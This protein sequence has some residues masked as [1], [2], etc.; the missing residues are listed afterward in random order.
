MC[1]SRCRFV[2]RTWKRSPTRGIAAHW[3]YKL[4]DKSL[5][6]PHARAREWLDN[7]VELQADANSEEFLESVKIDLF[8]DK[9]YVFTPRG[10]IRR[11]PRGAT[12]VDFAYAVHTEIGNRCVSAMVD[13]RRVPLRTPLRNG[14]TVEIVTQRGAKPNPLWLNFVV[15]AKARSAIKNFMKQMRDSEA[16]ALGKRLMETA[17]R[18]FN[19][20]LKDIEPRT[21][22]RVARIDADRR[23]RG[24]LQDRS[25]LGHHLAPLAGAPARDR[26]RRRRTR[27]GVFAQQNHYR[28]YRG[29]GGH[30]RRVAV[31]RFPDD[32]IMGYLSTG[33]GVVIHRNDCG[34][35][36]E[37]RKQPDKWVTVSWEPGTDAEFSV[38]VRVEALNELGVLAAVATRISEAKSNIQ[39]VNVIER[40]PESSSMSFTV[41]VRDTE[42]LER[43]MRGIETMPEVVRVSR[44]CD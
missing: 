38:E 32:P 39:H 36:N 42:H 14:Q 34:N 2:P 37:F 5:S 10:E 16:L 35:L 15:T 11:L 8:P 41:Q 27:V 29:H 1:R 40:D 4:G 25:D 33:R 24:A 30:L 17:L 12:I 26:C 19:V 44:V 9:V 18:E 43:V 23:R 7:L 31:T 21:P 22:R 20:K 6:T 28:R 3:L 13:R